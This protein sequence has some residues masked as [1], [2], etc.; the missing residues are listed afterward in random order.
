MAANDV[1]TTQCPFCK[2][3]IRTGAVLCKHCGSRLGARGPE[4]GGVCPYCKES[5]HPEATR[6][7]HCRSDLEA[8]EAGVREGGCGCGCGPSGGPSRFGWSPRF[9]L[10]GG[11]IPDPTCFHDCYWYCVDHGGDAEWCWRGCALI[12]PDVVVRR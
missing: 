5:I 12:C 1:E 6:C 9:A 4:H 10:R 11:T 3:E 2:E 7:K 8:R